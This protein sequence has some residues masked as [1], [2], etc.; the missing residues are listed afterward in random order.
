MLEFQPNRPNLLASHA[1]VRGSDTFRDVLCRLSKEGY[2]NL[3]IDSGAFTAFMSGAEIKLE[4]YIKAC[5]EHYHN[6]CWQYVM[7]DKIRD[8]KQTRVNAGKMHDAGLSPMGVWVIGEK[9][10]FLKDLMDIN[11]HLCVAGGFDNSRED[12]R[13]RYQAA[14]RHTNKRAQIHGLAF[15]KFPDM[16]QLPLNSVDS[17][18]Y[19]A[20][21]RFGKCDVFHTRTGMKSHDGHWIKSAKASDIPAELKRAFT[22]AGLKGTERMN[23]ELYVGAGSFPGGV[24]VDAHLRYQ[25]FSEAQGLK[26]FLAVGGLHWTYI[27]LKVNKQ[28][29]EYGGFKYHEMQEFLNNKP[30]GTDPKKCFDYIVKHCF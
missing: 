18:T 11:E 10:E 26:H 8:P 21:Q 5:R 22:R 4:D 29:K 2:I 20:G 27:I 24:T 15:V 19:S 17:S 3:M 28:I 6:N 13:G 12:M 25:R 7:L 14:Y 16:Y 30:P 23:K 1:Y 9:K